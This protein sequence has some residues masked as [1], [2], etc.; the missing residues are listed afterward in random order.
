LLNEK[1]VE[2]C[3]LIGVCYHNHH[4][5]ER[6]PS[7]LYIMANYIF[8]WNMHSICVLQHNIEV[9]AA[10]HFAA[11]VHLKTEVLSIKILSDI[12]LF[13]TSP[14]SPGIFILLQ[15]IFRS[16]SPEQL[17]T[18]AVQVGLTDDNYQVTMVTIVSRVT[19]KYMYPVTRDENSRVYSFRLSW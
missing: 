2:I 18:I 15:R 13:Q 3:S 6:I 4:A 5:Q 16:Q 17:K 9:L 1:S 10:M 8:P 12:C 19:A 11:S 14:E 7:Q